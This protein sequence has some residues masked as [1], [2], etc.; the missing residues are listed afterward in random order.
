[1]NKYEER[2][3]SPDEGDAWYE[4]NYADFCGGDAKN[5]PCKT[6][7]DAL[8]MVSEKPKKSF[9]AYQWWKDHKTL[10]NKPTNIGATWT[11]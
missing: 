1:L 7:E 4:I 11:S 2:L 10:H 8:K 6:Y 3:N 9:I 5:E